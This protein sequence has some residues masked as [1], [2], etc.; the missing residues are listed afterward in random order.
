IEVTGSG[1]ARVAVAC[2][3][4]VIERKGQPSTLPA[5]HS[6]M[7]HAGDRLRISAPRHTAAAYLAVEGG[8]AITP[9]L[10][11]AATYVQ[12][13]LGGHCGRPLRTGDVLNLVQQESLAQPERRY[14]RPL[15][16]AQPAVL[17]IMAGPQLD[18]FTDAALERLVSAPYRI[19]PASNRSGL[20]LEGPAIEHAAGHDLLSEGVATGSVQVPGS[21]QPVILIADHPTVGGYPKIATLISADWP[22]AGRL[23]IGAS[24]R[25]ALCEDR[26]AGAARR[27][28]REWMANQ[29]AT[30]ET[31]AV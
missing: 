2:A 19:A 9:V 14:A 24:F 28:Q 22:A 7:L 27:E 6:A 1:T 26:A 13:D 12:G 10:G 29:V 25:F 16:L 20:R 11:S 4:A 15:H 31:I 18:H 21:G 3:D 8:Y 30:I 5:W 23:R 17:R